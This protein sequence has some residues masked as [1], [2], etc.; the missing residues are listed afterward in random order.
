MNST[1]KQ[2][3]KN[4][5]KVF[6]LY[7]VGKS[8][9][10][11]VQL[12][13]VCTEE[14]RN[15]SAQD[16]VHSLLISW[17]KD[18]WGFPEQSIGPTAQ[19]KKQG[20]T[21]NSLPP[22]FCPKVV[23]FFPQKKAAV[24]RTLLSSNN[25]PSPGRCVRAAAIIGGYSGVGKDADEVRDSSGPWSACGLTM[26]WMTKSFWIL[27]SCSRVLSVSSFPEKNQR[28]CAVSMSCWACSCFFSCPMVSAMLALR[29][30]SL[31][32]ESRTCTEKRRWIQWTL[33]LCG[34]SNCGLRTSRT[35]QKYSSGKKKEIRKKN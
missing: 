33:T 28:C 32:E 11:V 9:L 7:L 6:N 34:L 5:R 14:R 30:R 4:N 10:R 26:T 17:F 25:E 8:R 24:Y 23:V 2:K 18:P 22:W 31:P 13:I 19:L 29:R 35:F 20:S 15:Q 16:D 3:K 1:R 12:G 27:V 21:F